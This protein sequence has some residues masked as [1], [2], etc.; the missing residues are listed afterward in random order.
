MHNKR[1]IQVTIGIIGAMDEEVELLQSVMTDTKTYKIANSLFI[2][3]KM[4]SKEVVLLKSGIGK[5]NAAMTTTILIERFNP[6]SIINTGSAGGFAE[7]L[8]VGDVVISS[9]VVHHDVD[10]T[11]FD[12]VYGQVPN[13]PPTFKA[14]Q[15]LINQTTQALEQLN[16]TSRI[17]LIAT[18]DSF[19]NDAKRIAS[20]RELFPT[21]LAAEMEG[22]AIAQVCYQYDVPFVI[23]RALSDIAGKNAP[24]SFN[25]FL[26]LAAENAAN[27]IIKVVENN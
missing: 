24:I 19:M 11:A 18:G 6:T 22:A 4:G 13:L 21:M 5:V 25:D 20:I 9:E 3:G 15:S 8:N 23:I 16:V 27:L 17:G 26:K 1:G 14:D 7:D 10:V 12:Y 2:K